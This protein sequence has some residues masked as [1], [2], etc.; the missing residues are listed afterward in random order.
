MVRFGFD[1]RDRLEKTLD[2]IDA[3]LG[4]G[5]YHYRYSDVAVEEGCFLACTFWMVEARALLGQQE[6]AWATLDAATAA[7]GRGVGIFTEMADPD[8]GAFLGNLPQ[9]LTHLAHIMA[10][11]VL[12]ERQGC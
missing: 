7:L 6:R 1:G 10:L 9:G 3:E 5:P 4:A 8:T 2:A 11:N 12:E